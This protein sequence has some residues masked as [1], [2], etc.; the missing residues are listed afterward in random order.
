MRRA[1]PDII[2]EAMSDAKD[3]E[4]PPGA[5][6]LASLLAELAPT[7][8]EGTYV[9]A[10]LR[11]GVEI[12]NGIRPFA[13][14]REPE[15]TALIMRRDDADAAGLRH[16]FPARLITLRVNSSLAA[17]GLTAAIAAQLAAAGIPANVI[18]GLHHDHLL[19]PEANA[20]DALVLLK[21]L[22][23]AGAASEPA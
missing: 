13:I 8:A 20:A 6:G 21:G 14:I 17:V 2:I 15:E 19:V 9:Y 3:G 5:R 18:A 12:P 16:V 23:A 4:I 7:L 10:R 22:S 1:G 11:E